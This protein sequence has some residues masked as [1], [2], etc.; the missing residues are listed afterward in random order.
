VSPDVALATGSAPPLDGHALLIQIARYPTMPLP[1]VGDADDLATLLRDPRTCGYPREQVVVLQDGAATRAAIEHAVEDLVQRAGADA[2]V[3][4]YFSGHG[5][6]VGGGTFLLPVDVGLDIPA[7]A[8]PVAVVARALARLR[9]RKVLLVFDCCHAGALEA[10]DIQPIVPGLSGPALDELLQGRGWVLFAS[11]DAGECSYVVRGDTNGLFTKHL[12]GGLRG[13]VASDDGYV[14]VFD[15]FEYLQPRV[16]RERA[17]QHPV[18]KCE[19][20]ENFAIARYRGGERGVVPTIEDGHRYHVVLSFAE[21]AAEFVHD[22]LVPRLERAGL[23]VATTTDIVDLGVDRVAGLDRGLDLARRTV[24]VVTRGY[25]TPARADDRYAG[26]AALMS[27]HR[28]IE[29]GRYSVIP[30]YLDDPDRVPGTPL[31]LRSLA[32]VRCDRRVEEELG[33]LVRVLELQVS[34]P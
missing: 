11:S 34:Q 14:R 8:I 20:R 16:V 7:S 12:L 30:L 23:R 24:V 27:K 6:Q 21:D 33:R 22:T 26:Y 3:L 4:I 18:F 31:W 13:G 29:Q 32:G 15:L 9:A 19:L 1:D 2:T 10:K 28:D 25:L 5:G 17:G